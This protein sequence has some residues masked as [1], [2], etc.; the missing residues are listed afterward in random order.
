MS[1]A[2]PPS[3][4]SLDE[5]ELVRLGRFCGEAAAAQ[6]DDLACQMQ[7]ASRLFA[8]ALGRL[9]QQFDRV[10]VDGE[11]PA[12]GASC[13]L[14]LRDAVLALQAEDALEQMLDASVRRAR[15]VAEG[16]RRLTPT[17]VDMV[18]QIEQ[19]PSREA[20]TVTRLGLQQAS[21]CLLAGE[22]VSQ[23]VQQQVLQAGDIDLF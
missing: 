12:E 9:R 5:S 13:S 8:A 4:A 7:K 3:S 11:P 10:F 19:S 18:G 15:H 2:T 20:R 21:A 17:L 16:L 23:P 14:E 6:V 22:S 1:L